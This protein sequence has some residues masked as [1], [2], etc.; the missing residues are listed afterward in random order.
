MLRHSV[1]VEINHQQILEKQK[2]V[3]KMMRM[4]HEKK[5][6]EKSKFGATCS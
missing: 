6:T 1:V 3:E 2:E 4:R 5:I